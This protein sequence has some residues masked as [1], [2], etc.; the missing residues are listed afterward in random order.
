MKQ[1]KTLYQHV[2]IIELIEYSTTENRLVLE[3]A[4]EN[5]HK[6]L[7]SKYPYTIDHALNWAA[8]VASGLSHMHRMKPKAIIHRDIKPLNLLFK[9]RFLLI[10]IC[11]FGLACSFKAY[12]SREQG[13]PMWMAP[14][15]ARKNKYTEKCDVYSWAITFW[16]MLARQS[17]SYPYCDSW[18][19]ALEAIWSDRR[20]PLLNDCPNFIEKIL[21]KCWAADPNSRPTIMQVEEVMEKILGQLVSPP[22]PIRLWL[23]HPC[24]PIFL[25]INDKLIVREQ[26]NSSSKFDYKALGKIH[27]GLTMMNDKLD[28][29][30]RFE[31]Y[32]EYNY[33]LSKY[34][35]KQFEKF[36]LNEEK[37]QLKKLKDRNS[38]TYEVEV[39]KMKIKI[40]SIKNLI[41][42]AL[43]RIENIPK[44]YFDQKSAL[45]INNV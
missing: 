9:N 36:S 20:P 3:L 5:L 42:D 23:H 43:E 13:T 7:E 12:L 18:S 1:L 19:Y 4:D 27:S 17:P 38:L 10:K 44:K 26:Q 31:N 37:E 35:R 24:D 8:Q 34:L 41:E 45:F 14:E 6:F 40:N 22:P 33:N 11:D 39:D 29:A 2:N 25:K 16:Q 32:L 21:T 30:E 15:V 28:D